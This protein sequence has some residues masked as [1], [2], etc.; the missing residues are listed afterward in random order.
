[1]EGEYPSGISELLRQDSGQ[2]F[3]HQQ[4][5]PHAK[6]ARGT[7]ADIAK[8]SLAVLPIWLSSL[9]ALVDNK[10]KGFLTTSQRKQRGSLPGSVLCCVCLCVCLCLC[11]SRFVCLSASACVLCPNMSVFVCLCLCLSVSICVSL[12]W[13]YMYVW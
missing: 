12:H 2:E 11:L 8:A 9:A 4:L 10:V 6:R 3:Q 1:M 13:I 7:V 5:R